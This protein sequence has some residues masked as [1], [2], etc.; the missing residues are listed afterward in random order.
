MA[1]QKNAKFFIA[2]E[3]LDTDAPDPNDAD[4]NQSAFEAL[5][6]AEVK[7][8]GKIPAIGSISDLAS[9]EE[10]GDAPTQF[11]KSKHTVGNDTLQCRAIAAD[12]GQIAMGV[13]GAASYNSEV[14]IKIEMDDMPSGGTTN[15]II[16]TR[17]VVSGPRRPNTGP[18]D[19]EVKEF[20]VGYV[21][22]EIE[23]A[24]T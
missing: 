8:T 16:Y 15:T 9:Y 7:G 24:A 1:S 2:V 18:S 6:W 17:A 20:N 10:F 19:F 4:L 5:T 13:A 12:D 11:T 3:A 14:A 23:V 21:Q 22:N